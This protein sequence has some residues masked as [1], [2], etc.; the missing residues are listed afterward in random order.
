[1]TI[2]L[3]TKFKSGNFLEPTLLLTLNL[4]ERLM[5]NTCREREIL[6]EHVEERF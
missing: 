6:Q 2:S 5:K 3:E 4:L 1:M